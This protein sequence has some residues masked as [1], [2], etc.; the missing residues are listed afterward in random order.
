[1]IN[2]FGGT[3]IEKENKTNLNEVEGDSIKEQQNE[4]FINKSSNNELKEDSNFEE[5]N[6]GGEN[7]TEE[8]NAL[9]PQMQQDAK[10][11]IENKSLILPLKGTITSRFGLRNPE[12]PTVPKNHTGIDIAVNEGTVFIASMDGIV[13]EV[14][15]VR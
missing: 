8:N 9:L 13:E 5:E 1:M 6:I 15:S 7:L 12:T 3:Q 10:Y 14:S 2:L 4:D 11:I